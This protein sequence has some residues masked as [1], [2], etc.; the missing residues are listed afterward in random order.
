MDEKYDCKQV[1][2]PVEIKAELIRNFEKSAITI[3]WDSNSTCPFYKIN[4]NKR[5][6]FNL[7]FFS[8][9]DRQALV[10]PEMETAP[11]AQGH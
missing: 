7:P 4:Q 11:S 1:I 10:F 5:R 2:A 8:P 3:D 6:R 9:A